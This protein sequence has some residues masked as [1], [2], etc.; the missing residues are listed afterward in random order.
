MQSENGDF[1]HLPVQCLCEFLLSNSVIISSENTRDIQLISYLQKL[2]RDENNDHQAACEVLE[3]FLRRLSSTSKFGRQS[4]IRGLKLL[5]KI[6]QNQ[7]EDDCEDVS[8]S[9][10]LLKYLPTIPSFGYIRPVVIAQLRSACQVENSPELIMIYI[11][12]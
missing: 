11:Q 12:V 2:L 9:D 1:S 3:Y 4:A 5:L 7:V 8:E 6:F 10:W